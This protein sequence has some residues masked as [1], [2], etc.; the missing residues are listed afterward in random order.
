MFY[1]HYII[2]SN[3]RDKRLTCVSLQTL[4]NFLF[5]TVV[6][7]AIG[8]VVMSVLLWCA[9]L[10][11]CR[12]TKYTFCGRPWIP[13][14]RDPGHAEAETTERT[15]QPSPTPTR[16][17]SAPP[18]ASAP[19]SVSAYIPTSALPYVI[20]YTTSQE[21]SAQATIISPEAAAAYETATA[22]ATMRPH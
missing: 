12:R 22:V 7:G 16:S 13:A 18:P 5:S 4:F 14:N 2:I 6:L 15:L 3:F 21:P 20:P 8:V 1:C 10:I 19:P 17:R 11:F 9:F